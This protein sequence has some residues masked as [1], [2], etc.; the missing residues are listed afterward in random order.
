MSLIAHKIKRRFQTR[1]PLPVDTDAVSQMRFGVWLTDLD[2]FLHMTNTRYFQLMDMAVGQLTMRNGLADR[3]KTQR[4][5]LI[6]AYATLDN[7]LMMRVGG[8]YTLSSR[9][10]GASGEH[11]AVEHIFADRKG[12][13][14]RGQNLLSFS[15]TPS[16]Q[17]GSAT[18]LGLAHLPDLPDD[19]R[20]WVLD[21][22]GG[23]DKTAM[24]AFHQQ[25]I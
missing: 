18:G 17:D 23:L 16:D 10:I 22:Q 8:R 1:T 6:P 25:D 11:L 2:A 5:R 4:I 19:L 12:L 7:H 13:R 14:A 21:G 24:A 9:L 3:L 20:N 15:T